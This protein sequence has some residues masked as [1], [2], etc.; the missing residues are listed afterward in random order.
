MSAG[1]APTK[2]KRL[3]H[4]TNTV[5][6]TKVGVRRRDSSQVPRRGHDDKFCMSHWQEL[7]KAHLDVVLFGATRVTSAQFS[8]TCKEDPGVNRTGKNVQFVFVHFA[9]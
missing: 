9:A 4:Y 1:R 8:Q 7:R 5:P 3:R 6:K 2:K